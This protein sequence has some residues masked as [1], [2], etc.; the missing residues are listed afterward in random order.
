MMT[1]NM[2]L[3]GE[4]EAKIYFNNLV[5]SWQSNNLYICTAKY[6][7]NIYLY[8]YMILFQ[9]QSLHCFIKKLLTDYHI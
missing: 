4:Q 6:M 2:I 7:A 5:T 3:L 9:Q 8:M 1:S